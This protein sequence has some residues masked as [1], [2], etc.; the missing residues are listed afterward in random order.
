MIP[1]DED[2][3]EDFVKNLF[4][5]MTQIDEIVIKEVFCVGKT[6]NEKWALENLS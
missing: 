2:D 5:Q 4:S 3:S 6:C 1:D